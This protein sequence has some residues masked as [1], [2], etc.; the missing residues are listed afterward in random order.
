MAS[1]IHLET[2]HLAA[3]FG[4]LTVTA[5]PGEVAG[6]VSDARFLPFLVAARGHGTAADAALENLLT[7]LCGPIRRFAAGELRGHIDAGDIVEDLVQE[8]L[9]RL[10]AAVR[11]CRATSDGEIVSWARTTA[12]RAL[13]DMYRSPSSGLAA[14]QFAQELVEEMTEFATTQNQDVAA[15]NSPVMSCLLTIMM[16]AYNDAVETT[17]ELLWWRLIMGLE[18][19]EIALKF[20][21]SAAGAKRRFQRA[22]DTLRREVMRRVGALPV[23][24]RGEVLALLARFGYAESLADSSVACEAGESQVSA[25]SRTGAHSRLADPADVPIPASGPAEE[26]SIAARDAVGPPCTDPGFFPL[27]RGAAA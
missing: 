23:C 6:K 4:A 11:S 10:A 16:G 3:D 21:T 17:G 25:P 5:L 22:Q 7:A 15:L 24:E 27:S 8:T 14:R 13:I 2:S 26:V 20:S 12:R 1:A 18:W 19:T 9:I